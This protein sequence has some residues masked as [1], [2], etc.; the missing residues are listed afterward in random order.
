M[1][2]LTGEVTIR[3]RGSPSQS[4]AHYIDDTQNTQLAN[5]YKADNCLS[6]RGILQ[7]L[8][9]SFNPTRY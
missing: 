8:D 4:C 6:R 3:F 1:S 5:V 2:R 7:M 9:K